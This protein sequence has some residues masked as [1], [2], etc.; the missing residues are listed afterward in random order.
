MDRDS[1]FAPSTSSYGT[2]TST[3][4]TSASSDIQDPSQDPTHSTM[5]IDSSHYPSQA[6]SA[7]VRGNPMRQAVETDKAPPPLPFF[8]QAI[9]CQGMVYCSGQVGVSPVTKQLVDGG[10]G[11]R[12][13]QALNN[14]SA[15]LEA[16]NSSLS[17]VVECNVYLSDMTNF[18]AM[19]RVYDT[20]FERPKPC[21]TCVAVKELP[22]KT[23]VEIKCIAHLSIEE[24][25]KHHEEP[26]EELHVPQPA[27]ASRIPFVGDF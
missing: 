4:G 24:H 5:S 16:A 13:A 19:N 15:V 9:I 3:A 12:T 2:A 6:S 17:N 1:S 20:F 26:P 10:V 14:L 23:D 11:D 7:T 25:H 22:L 18:A 8:E 27:V 21:R